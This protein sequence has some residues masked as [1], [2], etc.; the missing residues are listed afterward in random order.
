MHVCQSP[1]LIPKTP[2]ERSVGTSVCPE[3]LFP[4]HM[5]LLV[6]P[7]QLCFAP[8][9]ITSAPDVNTDGTVHLLSLLQPGPQHWADPEVEAHECPLL[10]AITSTPDSNS[11]GTLILDPLFNPKHL[12]NPGWDMHVKLVPVVMI[13]TPDSNSEGT[14]SCF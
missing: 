1:A 4:K 7:I 12:A 8:A 6:L 9:A 3:V 10:D 11:E 2:E 14:S 13:S 5:T